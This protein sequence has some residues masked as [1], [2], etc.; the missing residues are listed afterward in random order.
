MIGF[1]V[2]RSTRRHF[3]VKA[4]HPAYEGRKSP[5]LSE[6][7]RTSVQHQ[8]LLVRLFSEYINSLPNMYSGI[9]NFCVAAVKL[10]A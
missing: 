5:F 8:T 6:L 1:Q 3:E 2:R 9:L 7:R 4:T 10:A